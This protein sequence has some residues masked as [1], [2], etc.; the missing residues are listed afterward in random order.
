MRRYLN[1]SRIRK[2]VRRNSFLIKKRK[3]K[4]NP[5]TV[6]FYSVFYIRTCALLRDWLIIFVLII[7][8]YELPN[9]PQKTKQNYSFRFNCLFT[10][11]WFPFWNSDFH[12]FEVDKQREWN[13]WLSLKL[14]S[15]CLVRTDSVIQCTRVPGKQN[16][17][18]VNEKKDNFKSPVLYSLHFLQTHSVKPLFHFAKFYTFTR[19]K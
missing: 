3:C 15:E 5:W 13:V 16:A 11:T 10:Y 2:N 7:H 9:P 1:F 12:S 6:N 8:S 14:P 18:I 4:I 17:N 19:S